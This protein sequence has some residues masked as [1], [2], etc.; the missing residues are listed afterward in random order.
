LP[1]RAATISDCDKPGIVIAWPPAPDQ[2]AKGGPKLTRV[3][4]GPRERVPEISQE[5]H[6]RRGAAA[7]QLWREMVRRVEEGQSPQGCQRRFADQDFS[8]AYSAGVGEDWL[9][10]GCMRP[11]PAT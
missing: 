8:S 6:E 11:A 4:A 10:V 2:E 7:D 1:E 9:F 5:E 3:I